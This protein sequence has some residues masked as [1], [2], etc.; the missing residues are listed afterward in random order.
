ML[1]A[2]HKL[3]QE[4]IKVNFQ[5]AANMHLYMYHHS[6]YCSI[7]FTNAYSYAFDIVVNHGIHRLPET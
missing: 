7:K 2:L 4:G 1:Q 5:S 3:R 6:E